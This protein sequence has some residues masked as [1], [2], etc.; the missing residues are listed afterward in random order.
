MT[1]RPTHNDSIY[2]ASIA[3]RGK[4]GACVLE[5]WLLWN[6]EGNT[7]LEVKQP[8]T[9]R[10]RIAAAS[11][12]NVT[13]VERCSKIERNTA[14]GITKR[15]EAAFCPSFVMVIGIVQSRIKIAKW[16]W[17]ISFRCH[18]GDMAYYK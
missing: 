18:R 5:L 10:D 11:D 2:C 12:R 8:I 13:E 7:V 4:N 9:Q 3:S 14:T 17:N 15:E 6:T 1:D 16:R